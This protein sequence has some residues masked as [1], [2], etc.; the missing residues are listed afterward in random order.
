MTIMRKLDLEVETI[1]A[2]SKVDSS[3][4]SNLRADT[5]SSDDFNAKVDGLTSQLNVMQKA[6]MQQIPQT[7]ST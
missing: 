7:E 2:Q 6:I 3:M 4:A 5:G 1:D